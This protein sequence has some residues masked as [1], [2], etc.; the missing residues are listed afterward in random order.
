MGVSRIRVGID[1]RSG[2]SGSRDPIRPAEISG[3][4]KRMRGP[5]MNV[6]ASE[7]EPSRRRNGK[8]F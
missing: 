5:G 1:R 7:I 4:R 3:V 6:K 2:A 8:R